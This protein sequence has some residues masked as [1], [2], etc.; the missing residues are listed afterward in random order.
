MCIYVL[1]DVWLKVACV[2]PMLTYSRIIHAV[3]GFPCRTRNDNRKNFRVFYYMCARVCV[4]AR[5][6]LSGQP[7]WHMWRVCMYVGQMA[8]DYSQASEPM[9]HCAELFYNS[10]ETARFVN[11][12]GWAALSLTDSYIGCEQSLT[13]CEHGVWR[14]DSWCTHWTLW[15]HI[16]R[17]YLNWIVCELKI[18]RYNI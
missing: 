14:C 10:W 12:I 18:G 8:T 17:M 16:Y 9:K 5:C 13:L 3:F 1:V 15:F 7:T 4:C 6:S 2:A 11:W